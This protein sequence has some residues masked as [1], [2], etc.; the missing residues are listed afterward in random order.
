[1]A[2][3]YENKP[4]SI[5]TK[6]VNIPSQTVVQPSGTITL[7]TGIPVQ[8]TGI[9]P[10]FAFVPYAMIP[11]NFYADNNTNTYKIQFVNWHTTA[12]TL[13]TTDFVTIRYIS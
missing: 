11:T 13:Q 12:I 3:G 5:Y 4:L 10:N 7:D 1:M 6:G 9:V 2:E 8:A